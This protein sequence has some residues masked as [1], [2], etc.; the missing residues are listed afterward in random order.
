LRFLADSKQT[1]EEFLQL[2]NLGFPEWI[3][4]LCSGLLGNAN[5]TTTRK[6][7]HPTPATMKDAFQKKVRNERRDASCDGAR[8]C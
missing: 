8:R 7:V 3:L 1:L 5:I 2:T 4:S 6:Y